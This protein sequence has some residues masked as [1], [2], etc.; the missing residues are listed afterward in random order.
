MESLEQRREKAARIEASPEDYKVCEGCGSIVK[1]AA[2]I[3]P[4]C[5]H[6]RFDET[7]ERVIEQARE[8]GSREATT[9]LEEDL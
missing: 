9:I 7:P 6:Y 4:V 3:C 8:L 5:K 1:L 2:V